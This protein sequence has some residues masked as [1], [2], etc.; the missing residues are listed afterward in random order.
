MSIYRIIDVQKY[1]K[2]KLDFKMIVILIML[3]I[4]EC[5]M[6]YI[7]I[8]PLSIFNCIILIIILIMMNKNFILAITNQIKAKLPIK[9]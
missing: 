6:Y 4:I 3:F 7:R 1:V 8:I 5:S 2:L 9:L